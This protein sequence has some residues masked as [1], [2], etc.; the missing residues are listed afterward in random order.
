MKKN[1]LSYLVNLDTPE[2]NI[3]RNELYFTFEF[4]SKTAYFIVYKSLHRTNL[5]NL[6][7]HGNSM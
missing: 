1:I 3:N 2:N 4:Q 7:Q 6:W 5:K